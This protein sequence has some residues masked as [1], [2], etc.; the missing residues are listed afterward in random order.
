MD[1]WGVRLIEHRASAGV[2][3]VFIMFGARD[4]KPP[5]TEWWHD[6]AGWATL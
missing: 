6:Q 5:Y 4:V 2:Q 3:E 1:A